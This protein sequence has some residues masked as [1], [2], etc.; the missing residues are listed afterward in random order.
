MDDNTRI[1]RHFLACIKEWHFKHCANLKMDDDETSQE[2]EVESNE[3]ERLKLAL[4]KDNDFEEEFDS[5]DEDGSVRNEV[6]WNDSFTGKKRVYY[7]ANVSMFSRY[8]S[9]CGCLHDMDQ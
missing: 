5:E 3:I 8:N 2:M 9:V 7:A 6:V 1:S 4:L